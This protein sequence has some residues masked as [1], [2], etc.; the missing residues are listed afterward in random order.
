M[1]VL[2]DGGASG[3]DVVKQVF[4]AGALDAGDALEDV[5]AGGSECYGLGGR[6][7]LLGGGE[8]DVQLG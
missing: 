2:A 8:V 6:R 1:D 4:G 3:F 7:L 5:A